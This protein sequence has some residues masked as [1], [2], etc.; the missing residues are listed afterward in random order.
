M[1]D[2]KKLKVFYRVNWAHDLLIDLN[3]IWIL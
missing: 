1:T 3:L 2:G